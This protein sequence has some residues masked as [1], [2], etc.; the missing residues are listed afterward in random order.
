[1]AKLPTIDILDEATF[2]RVLK[3]FDNDPEKFKQWLKIALQDFVRV[4]E[5]QARREAEAAANINLLEGTI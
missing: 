2:A 1:M 4:K 3:A 5:E